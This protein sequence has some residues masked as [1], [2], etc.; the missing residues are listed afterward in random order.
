MLVAE[1]RRAP[2]APERRAL[3]GPERRGPAAA[4]RRVLV[5]EVRRV[6]VAEERGALIPGLDLAVARMPALLRDLTGAVP[7]ALRRAVLRAA[8]CTGI[9]LPP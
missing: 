7:A 3:A 1:M 2:V 6:L 8:V 9:D 4:A 5:A